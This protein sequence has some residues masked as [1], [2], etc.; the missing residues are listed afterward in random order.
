[1]REI[2]FRGKR[3][4]GEWYYG[5]HAK[6]RNY[7]DEIYSAIIENDEETKEAYM[8]DLH[9]VIPETVGQFTGLT[10]KNG[11]ETAEKFAKR[12]KDYLCDE[13]ILE[14]G[15]D[16]SYIITASLDECYGKID[17]ICKEITEG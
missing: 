3:V 17:E 15:S 12:L 8:E 14:F 10:D 4:N 13:S 11:K 5:Y 6:F 7:R 1:M 16:D 9:P 2:L